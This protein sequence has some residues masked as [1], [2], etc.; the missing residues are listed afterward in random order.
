[1]L[2]F[3]SK[4]LL[5]CSK[6]RDQIAL[7]H[8]LCSITHCHFSMSL[9]SSLADGFNFWAKNY[10]RCWVT[11][12]TTL[13]VITGCL[14]W[15]QSFNVSGWWIRANFATADSMPPSW[16]FGSLVEIE[17]TMKSLEFYLT[18]D[19]MLL[20][21]ISALDYAWDEFS[22]RK[23]DGLSKNDWKRSTHHR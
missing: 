7:Y 4:N 11:C 22:R 18:D 5:V 2:Y 9:N 3:V 23:Q 16:M 6:N 15:P 13:C 19:I 14:D 17:K 20:W 8:P 10:K 21:W 12:A 1:M